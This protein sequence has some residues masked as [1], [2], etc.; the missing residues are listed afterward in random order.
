MFK[1]GWIDPLLLLNRVST[2]REIMKEIY[3]HFGK[4]TSILKTLNLKTGCLIVSEQI[5]D[6]MNDRLCRSITLEEVKG[7]VF[8]SG[9]ARASGRDEFPESFYQR[10]WEICGVFTTV[11]AFLKIGTFQP[12]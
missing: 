8:Q 4:K 11:I 3:E 5:T 2:E 7:V 9:G 6:E 1:K 10:N 12:S